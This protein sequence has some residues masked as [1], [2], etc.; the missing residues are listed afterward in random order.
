MEGIL[1][2]AALIGGLLTMNR[3]IGVYNTGKEAQAKPFNDARTAMEHQ[4]ETVKR[5]NNSLKTQ[6]YN[7][8]W[9]PVEELSDLNY[10]GEDAEA[11]SDMEMLRPIYEE[12]A[13]AWMQ[14]LVDF[15]TAKEIVVKKP[16]LIRNLIGWGKNKYASNKQTRTT[17]GS[18]KTPELVE[19][20]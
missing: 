20:V 16:E 9:G 6:L 7:A 5:A 15:E 18:N 11:D 1:A 2:L 10:S 8:K 3:F 12:F 4:L 14:K 13:P 19:A 17:A